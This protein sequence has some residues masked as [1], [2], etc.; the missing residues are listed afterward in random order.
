LEVGHPRVPRYF[1]NLGILVNSLKLG[2]A[3]SGKANATL[4][5]IAQDETDAA[6]SAGGTP[7]SHT[8]Q[9]FH[10]FQGRIRKDGA[11][12]GNI[13]GAELTYANNLDAVRVIRD[14]GKI[15]GADP[16]VAACTGT[17]SARFADMVLLGAATDGTPMALEFAWVIDADRS[18][19]I[20][21]P[22][23]YLPRPSLP[24]TG[25]AG[26]E[27]RFDWQAAK[28]DSG[29]PGDAFVTVTLKNDVASY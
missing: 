18:L 13:T 4:A 22:S 8:L 14:D 26:I 23:V 7:I 28:P 5:V 20:A 6:A 27:A 12:L 10:Q 2:W 29:T 17:L 11:A 24:I 19:T 15:D 1:L 25:P 9:R 3:P 16:G 21:L